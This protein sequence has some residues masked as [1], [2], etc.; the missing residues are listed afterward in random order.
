MAYD[1][2]DA[3]EDRAAPRRGAAALGA[4]RRAAWAGR[5]HLARL[6][7]AAL[8]VIFPP[9]CL[10]CR[11]AT[12]GHGALCP[13]CWSRINFIERPF[14]ERLGT[15]FPYDFGVE[16][17]Y[18]PEAI[19]NP[20]A[21]ARA[22]AVVRF[23]DGPARMLVHRLKYSDRIELARPLGL[24]MA[25]AGQEILADADL[26]VPVPLHRRRLIWR[27]FNQANALALSVGRACGKK[28]DPFVLVRVKPTTPQVGLSRAPRAENVQGAFAVP[29]EA[30]LW[31]EGR[32]IV[33]IDD[34]TTTG[35]TLNAAARAL[36]RAGARR[37]DVLVF[38][39]VVTAA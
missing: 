13:A 11:K 6:G 15:P 32:T 3:P 25:R 27:R 20:P 37:V 39:R 22:R 16:G 14:C 21:Y 1:I 31:I 35:A 29:E 24:W 4:L 33:L 38:A 34:V 2:A 18:S 26:L 5:V 12:Q 28:V 7:G 36:L 9:V 17:L 30:R 19:A 23:E 8:D 10:A